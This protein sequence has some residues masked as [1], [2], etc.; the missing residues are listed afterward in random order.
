LSFGQ[1]FGPVAAGILIAL[2]AGLLVGWWEQRQSLLRLMLFM[3][4][5]ALTFNLGRDISLL[6]LWP[7]I[8]AYFFVHL[9]EMVGH[10]AIRTTSQLA[11][12][13]PANAAPVQ[14]SADLV[15]D[16]MGKSSVRPE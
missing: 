7:I 5:T 3:F 14:M 16:A 13:A 6:V 4:G 1:I 15:T 11:T 8:F 12:I 9:T 2:W 10:E